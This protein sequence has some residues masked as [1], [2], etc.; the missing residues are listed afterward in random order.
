MAEEWE[1][2]DVNLLAIGSVSKETQLAWH[3][4]LKAQC[5]C[6]I[7]FP[8]VI[9]ESGRVAETFGMR[10]LREASV[11]TIRRSFVIDPNLRIRMIFDYPSVVPRNPDEVLRVIL[12]LKEHESQIKTVMPIKATI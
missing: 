12:S 5:D 11:H 8:V 1:A 9:D 6:E 3:E 2:A 10:Q 7:D 4:M